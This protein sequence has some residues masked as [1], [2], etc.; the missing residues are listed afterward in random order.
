MEVGGEKLAKVLAA[1]AQQ[2]DWR[3]RVL[4]NR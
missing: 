4:G 3:Y 2:L 1:S